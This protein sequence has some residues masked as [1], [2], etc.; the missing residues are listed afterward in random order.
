MDGNAFVHS[1]YERIAGDYYPTID[2]RCV[3]GFLEHYNPAGLC[4]D[5]CAPNGSGIV[6]TLIECGY[7]AIG[8]ADAFTDKI[9]ARWIVT[10]PPYARPLVDQIIT[11]QIQRVEAGEVFGLAVLLRAY[12][13][14]AKS[15]VDMFEHP[16]YAG[17]IKLRFRPWW[18]KER[19]KQPI[20]H[21][22]WQLWTQ[23]ANIVR[24]TIFYANGIKQINTH[25]TLRSAE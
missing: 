11:R 6:D 21:Y 20:H 1:N 25:L 15:R 16:L 19:K 24:P 18:S 9:E 8:C 3:Y 22:V 4:V 2:K 17:Q 13:D 14:Y 10:N 23:G 5:V 12:F 7:Q